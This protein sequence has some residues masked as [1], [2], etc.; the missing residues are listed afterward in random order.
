MII[1]W[2]FPDGMTKNQIDHVA[3]NKTWKSS[4]HDTRVKRSA[5]AGSD[6]H[7]V[8]AEIKMKLMALKKKRSARSKYCT[9]KLKG[10]RM[11]D[12][13]VIALATGSMPCT[14]YQMMKRRQSLT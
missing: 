5:D 11:K 2:T 6:H 13:F 1:T 10:Q 12:E 8:V 7:L 3:I 9:Y 14:T 4:L